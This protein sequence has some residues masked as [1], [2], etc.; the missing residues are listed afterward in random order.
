MSSYAEDEWW[1]TAPQLH[2]LGLLS[3]EAL[4]QMA[5]RD[6][7]MHGL[8]I[9]TTDGNAKRNPLVKI[10]A[11]WLRRQPIN[12][13]GSAEARF[14]SHSKLK[15]DV[16]THLTSVQ[17]QKSNKQPLAIVTLNEPA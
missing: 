10:A 8:L 2:A 13:E 12:S 15:S 14:G 9:K 6:E 11:S 7:T 1:W 5:D 4:A 3:E 17:K 16:A